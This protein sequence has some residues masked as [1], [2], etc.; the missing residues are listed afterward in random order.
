M[1]T[2]WHPDLRLAS[3]QLRYQSMDRRWRTLTNCC[4]GQILRLLHGG[5]RQR[6]MVRVH[7]RAGCGI[8][9]VSMAWRGILS[10]RWPARTGRRLRGP[11]NLRVLVEC[12]NIATLV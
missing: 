1:P 11:I 2:D 5:W 10:E 12:C 7:H 6:D 9:S 4:N 3:Q 8:A